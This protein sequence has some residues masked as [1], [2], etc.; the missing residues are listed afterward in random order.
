MLLDPAHINHSHTRSFGVQHLGKCLAVYLLTFVA[1][2]L[3]TVS[4]SSCSKSLYAESL[5][6]INVSKQLMLLTVNQRD[7]PS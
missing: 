7:P 3:A 6:F 1:T 4:S 5:T 2:K